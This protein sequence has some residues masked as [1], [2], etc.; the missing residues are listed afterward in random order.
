MRT[1]HIHLIKEVALIPLLFEAFLKFPCGIPGKVAVVSLGPSGAYGNYVVHSVGKN[2]SRRRLFVSLCKSSFLIW[3]IPESY[4]FGG[5]ETG[6]G[7]R[8]SSLM[9]STGE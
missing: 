9:N 6:N 7:H 8:I 5:F 1:A 2:G 4:I 3:L